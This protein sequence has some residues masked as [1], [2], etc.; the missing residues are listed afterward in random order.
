MQIIL[1]TNTSTLEDDNVVDDG[2][3]LSPSICGTCIYY[4]VQ[5]L[6]QV[7][8]TQILAGHPSHIP[9]NIINMWI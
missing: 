6:Q 5:S 3:R 4:A 9:K 8:C 7:Y 2:N 1:K